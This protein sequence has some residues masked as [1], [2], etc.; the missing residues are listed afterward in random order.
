MFYMKIFKVRVQQRDSMHF[1]PIFLTKSNNQSAMITNLAPCNQFQEL[2]MAALKKR[3]WEYIALPNGHF[4]NGTALR[5]QHDP[6][7]T[8]ATPETNSSTRPGSTEC[9]IHFACFPRGDVCSGVFSVSG[10]E[11]LT[12]RTGIHEPRAK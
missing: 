5:P 4:R 3:S 10:P 2:E 1:L 11:D 12:T 8:R 9:V 6:D 7:A